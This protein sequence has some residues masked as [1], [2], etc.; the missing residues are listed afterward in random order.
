MKASKIVTV[1]NT[2]TIVDGAM[3]IQDGKIADLGLA[4]E[5]KVK[6]GDSIPCVDYQDSVI[7]PGLI[8]CHTHLLI[9]I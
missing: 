9:H 6:Y 4:E 2:G 3:L 7:T 8:D 1:S 5:I